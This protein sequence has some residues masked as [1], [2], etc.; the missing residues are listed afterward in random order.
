MERVKPVTPTI[1]SPV[2]NPWAL[3]QGWLFTGPTYALTAASAPSPVGR[4]PMQATTSSSGTTLAVDSPNLIIPQGGSWGDRIGF[5]G[6]SYDAIM[7]GSA[8][9]PPPVPMLKLPTS[10]SP[11]RISMTA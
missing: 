1:G 2:D 4:A 3:H 5:P 8:T 7:A 11:G 9:N 10:Y 6:V